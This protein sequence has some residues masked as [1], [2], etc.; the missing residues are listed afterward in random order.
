MSRPA[1]LSG[2]PEW[3]PADR[4]VE[5]TCST[6]CDASSSCTDSPRSRPGP[7]S[8]SSRCCARARSTR[9]STSCGGCTPTATM[10]SA[11]ALGLHFDLTVPFARYVLQNAGHLEFPFRRY[12]IQKVWRGERPQEGRYREFTQADIDVIGRDTLGLPPRGRGRPGHGRGVPGAA[13]PARGDPGQQPQAGRGL[14]PRGRGH[15]R[16]RGA[17]GHR[18][19]RQDRPGQGR[20][21]A[22]VRGRPVAPRAAQSVPGAGRHPQRRRLVRRAGARTRRPAPA[23]RRGSGRAVRQW[24]RP[25]P[26]RMPGAVVA[27]LKIARGLDYYTGTV[28]ETQL[29][30]YE[31]VRVGLLR[32][33]LRR[34]RQRRPYHV[35]RRRD[36]A[37]ASPG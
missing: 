26:A 13:V 17:A 36:L 25:R 32:R 35:P 22:R 23:A 5:R 12:Q 30:G 3:L 19:A 37:R 16:R 31:Y 11:D 24:S 8:R 18:Q 14:L 15:R 2:F 1:A 33:P 21:P 4:I 34:A 10:P 29:V 6:R 27:D 28:Y 7:S 9:R 20:R